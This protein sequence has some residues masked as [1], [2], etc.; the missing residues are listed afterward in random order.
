MYKVVRKDICET[1]KKNESKFVR[2]TDTSVSYNDYVENMSKDTVWGTTAEISAASLTY[3]RD[4]FVLAENGK[5]K[6]WLR[7][8]HNECNG[9]HDREYIAIDCGNNHYRLWQTSEMPCFCK[10][11]A[12]QHLGTLSDTSTY[13]KSI[14]NSEF[15]NKKRYKCSQTN[16]K[17]GN[18]GDA[19]FNVN[20][21][22]NVLWYGMKTTAAQ[23]WVRRVHKDIAFWSQSTLFIPPRCAATKQMIRV[24]TDLTNAYTNDAPNAEAA[25]TMVFILPKL[26]LQRP[27]KFSSNKENVASLI[28]RM[29]HLKNGNL[30]RLYHDA[31]LRENNLHRKK[32]SG[33]MQDDDASKLRKAMNKGAVN[34]ALRVLSEDT[35][36]GPIPITRSIK[37]ILHAQ[38]PPART[39]SRDT[40]L[41]GPIEEIDQDFFGQ[42]NGSL[43]WK[44]AV[45][46]IGGAGPSGL[47]SKHLKTIL[48]KKYFGTVAT[49]FQKALASLA[50]KIA[51]EKCC[52]LEPL[53][54]RRLIPL[55]KKPGVRPIGVGEIIMRVFGQCIMEVMRVDTISAAGNLQVCTGQRAGSEAAIHAMREIFTEKNKE[56]VLMIDASNASNSI[57]REAM[58]HNISVKCPAFSQ[59]VHNTYTKAN[60]LY[61]SGGSRYIDSADD[62]DNTNIINSVEGTTQGDPIAMAMYGI[63]LSVLQ[64]SLTKKNP[65][66]ASVAYADDYIGSGSVEDLLK[67]WNDIV[68]LGPKYGYFPQ[69]R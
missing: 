45:R 55:D 5:G 68:E 69:F 39:A 57:N 63:G 47:T 8:A 23:K 34:Q 36:G 31:S 24:M 59:Y 41:R 16:T 53:L 19:E 48:S 52:H 1:L 9:D 67:W 14:N 40:K 44:K 32:I 49:D 51:T 29:D 26:L 27:H 61:I 42:I 22:C 12:T 66:I 28:I 17:K 60:K 56:A 3:D 50:V 11:Y 46:N 54:A 30:D 18:G 10:E 64:T 7:F 43:I 33:R 2:Y 65:E 62:E 13:E 38:H 37:K 21:T 15:T 35:K 20:N 25:L 6:R 58:I 4:I